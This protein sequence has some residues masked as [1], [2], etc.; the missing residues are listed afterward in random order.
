MLFQTPPSFFRDAHNRT[1]Q[2]AARRTN[3]PQIE[4]LSDLSLHLRLSASGTQYGCICRGT[5]SDVICMQWTVASHN[6]GLSLNRRADEVVAVVVLPQSA[7]TSSIVANR[8]LRKSQLTQSELGVKTLPKS[9]SH[10]L[11]AEHRFTRAKNV[12]FC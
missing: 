11:I 5:K 7:T 8:R 10:S 6:F 12:E 3:E 9:L 4:Q 1:G 2:G